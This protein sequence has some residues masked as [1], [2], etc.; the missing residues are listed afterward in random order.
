MPRWVTLSVPSDV[1]PVTGIHCCTS[2]TGGSTGSRALRPAE[3]VAGGRVGRDRAEVPEFDGVGAWLAGRPAPARAERQELRPGF[4]STH[5]LLPG[6][7]AEPGVE[8]GLCR[9]DTVG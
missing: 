1:S 7:L 3:R 2:R 8:G 4:P 5:A 6:D 9:G